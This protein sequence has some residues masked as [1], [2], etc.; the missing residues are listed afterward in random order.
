VAAC[1]VGPEHDRRFSFCCAV[2]S[3]R[4]RATPP[5]LR[6]LGRNL[7]TVVVLVSMMQHGVTEPRVRRLAAV[8]GVDRR[9]VARWRVWWREVFTTSGFWQAALASFMPPVDDAGL[10]ATLMARFAGDGEGG[11][12]AEQGLQGIDRAEIER[13]MRATGQ[14]GHLAEHAACVWGAD[15]RLL[16]FADRVVESA[17]SG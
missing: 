3:C 7:A 14:P 8:V 6:F 12:A 1:L 10:P 2:D 9:T 13:Q 17:R 5:S 16:G 11:D 4:R 15:L